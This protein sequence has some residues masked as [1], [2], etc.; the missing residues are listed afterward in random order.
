MIGLL[1]GQVVRRGDDHVI[2]ETHGVG[3]LVHC[4]ARTL[5]QLA[6]GK[7]IVELS[8]ETQV[9]EDA[10][11]LFG[12]SAEADQ[13]LF[14]L[15]QNIQGVGAR[16]ALS[17][18]SA[19][20]ADELLRAVAAQD[21][22]PLT[23]ASGVGPKLAGRIVAELKDRIAGISSLP[24]AV[25]ASRAGSSDSTGADVTGDAIA[26]LVQLGYG[27]SEVFGI[28]GALQARADGRATVESLIRDALRELA[29]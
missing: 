4:D 1:R 18:I 19:L 17:L 5:Q 24:S 12:F 9:R 11:T 3:Y 16:S 21:K 8:I 13:R 26:A 22:A 20:T 29:T 27:R 23:R 14:K 15:L 6:A 28:V 25:A 7:D 10:I 2:L